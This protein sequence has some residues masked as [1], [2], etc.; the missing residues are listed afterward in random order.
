MI[1]VTNMKHFF[2]AAVEQCTAFIKM[3]CRQGQ[4]ASVDF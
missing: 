3:N 4:A 1:A 2:A